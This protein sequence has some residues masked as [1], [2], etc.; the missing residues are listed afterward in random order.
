VVPT[1][2]LDVVPTNVLDVVPTH[3]LDVVPTNVVDIVDRKRS[4]LSAEV[5]TPSSV[6][7]GPVS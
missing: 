3:V 1:H 2:V 6:L 4:P 7:D 5:G